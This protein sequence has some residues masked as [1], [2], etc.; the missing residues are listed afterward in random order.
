MKNGYN[1]KAV[2]AE[3]AELLDITKKKATHLHD[4]VINVM[5]QSLLNGKEVN[6]PGVGVLFNRSLYIGNMHLWKG[7]KDTKVY[8]AF[9]PY[10]SLLRVLNNK[11]TGYM[12]IHRRQMRRYKPNPTEGD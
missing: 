8:T 2:I 4:T 9:I 3:L 7:G 12:Y 5:K 1:R 6:I 11:P 10:Q